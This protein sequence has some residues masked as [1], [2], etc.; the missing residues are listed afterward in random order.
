MNDLEI[1]LALEDAWLKYDGTRLTELPAHP[2]LATAARVVADFSGGHAGV[3]SLE[4]KPEH[5]APLIE[6][7]V[8]SEGLVDGETHVVIHRQSTAPGS[9]QALYTAVPV[10]LWQE[11]QGWAGAQSDHC[12]VTPVT[13]LMARHI[14]PGEGMILH[15]GRQLTFLGQQGTN[16]IHASVQAYS[17]AL[18]DIEAAASVLGDRV[19]AQLPGENAPRVIF[20]SLQLPSEEHEKA[21]RDAFARSSGIEPAT[22]PARRITGPD[23]QACRTGLPFLLAGWE[24]TDAINPIQAK[25]FAWAEEFLPALIVAGAVI[26][27]GLFGYGAYNL[28]RARGAEALASQIDQA[29][30]TK[31][32]EAAALEKRGTMPAGFEADYDFAKRIAR[33]EPAYNPYR[34]LTEIRNAARDVRVLRVRLDTAANA[35]KS[36]IVDVAQRQASPDPQA[37]AGFVE[38]LRLAGY[39]VTAIASTESGPANF[40]YRLEKKEQA[41]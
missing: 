37:L 41:R 30:Q 3:I 23:G 36:L 26:A 34:A 35:A 22:S 39:D 38:R 13:A 8:R 40:S 25:L 21:I 12:L 24:T 6:R 16:L 32:N 15:Y 31:E 7:K 11:M 20:C 2:R 14:A 10:E 1:I 9:T 4:G 27:V 28:S 29:A 33:L 19:R 18:D 5:A 17:R